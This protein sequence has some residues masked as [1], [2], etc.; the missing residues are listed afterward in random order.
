VRRYIECR[1]AWTPR[2]WPTALGSA[3]L[4]AA[5]GLALRPGVLAIVGIAVGVAV[6]VGNVRWAVWRHRHPIIPFDQ[7]ITELIRKRRQE[8]RWN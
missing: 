2:F 7:Y 3:A 4:V 5:F 6:L 8:A 1:R